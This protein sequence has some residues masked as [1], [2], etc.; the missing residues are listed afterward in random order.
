MRQIIGPWRQ[1]GH[2]LPD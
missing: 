1:C 2:R